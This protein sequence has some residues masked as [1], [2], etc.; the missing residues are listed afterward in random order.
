MISNSDKARIKKLSARF[1]VTRVLLFGSSTEPGPGGRDIDLAVEG[2]RPQD[3][4]R[5]YGELVFSLSKPVDLIDL[6]QRSK[7]S[8]IIRREGIPVYDAHQGQN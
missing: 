1:G 4:F 5:F 7:F 6:A 8:E 2:I 3:F